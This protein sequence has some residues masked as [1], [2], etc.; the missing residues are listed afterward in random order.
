[1]GFRL[2]GLFATDG[3]P[4]A[5][6]LTSPKT[7]EREVCL[8]MLARVPRTGPLTIVGDKGYAG[9]GFEA[10]A[11][12]LGALI[13]RPRRLLRLTNPWNVSSRVGQS[14]RVPLRT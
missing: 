5:L 3:T 1:M 4:R 7:G 14:R 8:N 12:E 6:T 10:Q 9:R 2:H 11:A 13:V